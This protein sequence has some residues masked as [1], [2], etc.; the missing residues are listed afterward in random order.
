MKDIEMPEIKPM[1]TKD[2]VLDSQP[3]MI[4]SQ[5]RKV[6]LADFSKLA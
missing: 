1:D 2:D 4:S 5:T 6:S 3:S